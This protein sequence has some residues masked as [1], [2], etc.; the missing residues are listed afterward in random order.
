MLA[1]LQPTLIS[2]YLRIVGKTANYNK[3]KEVFFR[4]Y[5][6]LSF[7]FFFTGQTYLIIIFFSTAPSS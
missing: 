2:L 6:L 7:L 1:E 4:N 5:L 3:D